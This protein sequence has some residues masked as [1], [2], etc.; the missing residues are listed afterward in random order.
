M[1]LLS[2]NLFSKVPDRTMAISN[3]PMTRDQIAKDMADGGK[4]M[5]GLRGT[6]S[7]PRSRLPVQANATMENFT[8]VSGVASAAVL[9]RLA[10][11]KSDPD[12]L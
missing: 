3:T 1:A 8:F 11:R 10:I 6:C 5:V 9:E 12:L 7:P 4:A 2:G